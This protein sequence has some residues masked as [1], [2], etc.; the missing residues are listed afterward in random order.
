M[1]HSFVLWKFLRKIKPDSIFFPFNINKWN[2]IFVR[3]NSRLVAKPNEHTIISTCTENHSI[4]KNPFRSQCI[5]TEQILFYFILFYVG[6]IYVY[7]T[8]FFFVSRILMIFWKNIY[9]YIF[10]IFMV[11]LSSMHV[12]NSL[13]LELKFRLKLSNK[14]I[15]TFIF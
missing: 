13:V 10:I 15:K 5:Y 12:Y 8:S 3:I 1:L 9:K 11:I 7:F 14:K 2:S 6:F 4:S